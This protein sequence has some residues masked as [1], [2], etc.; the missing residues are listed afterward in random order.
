MP[1]FQ[2][3]Y[4]TI[5]PILQLTKLSNLPDI[6]QLLSG[7]DWIWV[8]ICLFVYSKLLITARC[9]CKDETVGQ[10]LKLKNLVRL[11]V[12]KKTP[13]FIKKR[14]EEKKENTKTGYLWVQMLNNFTLYFFQNFI[15]GI[16]LNG[17]YRIH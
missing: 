11:Q 5:T 17:K 1:Y 9:K 7:R 12:L 10:K 4:I 13:T 15:I 16:F 8:Q 6:T 3:D 2:C 14:L